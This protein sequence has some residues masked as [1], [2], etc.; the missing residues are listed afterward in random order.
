MK[1]MHRFIFI[2]IFWSLGISSAT[3]A[4]IIQNTI[5]NGPLLIHQVR[6]ETGLNA[7][8][9]QQNKHQYHVPGI[10]FALHGSNQSNEAMLSAWK[11][12]VIRKG[13]ILVC[14]QQPE[15]NTSYFQ[16]NMDNRKA[17]KILKDE[18]KSEFG[19]PL[20]IPSILAG[21]SNGGSIAVETGLLFPRDFPTVISISGFFTQFIKEKLNRIKLNQF[22]RNRFFFITGKSDQSNPSSQKAFNA[23]KSA[24]L[25]V[26][27]SIQEL[28]QDIPVR[29]DIWLPTL[30]NK[31]LRY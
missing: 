20:Y 13:Y 3:T 31:K 18:I 24:Q 26:D 4:S 25:Q 1:T 9:L 8:V 15:G 22:K 21:Y 19:L 16:K 14:P 28:I 30:M 23:F 29:P 6:S 2:L 11:D 5:Q 12:S 7:L 27:L 17:I 10:I